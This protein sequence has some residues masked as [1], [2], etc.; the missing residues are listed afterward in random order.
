[1]LGPATR[2]PSRSFRNLP[3]VRLL[4]VGQLNTYDVLWADTVVFTDAT[5]G[6]V[7]R[8]DLVRL[9]DDRLR[10]ART[11]EVSDA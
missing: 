5:I 6:M 10:H 2:S 1:M 9:A 4:T 11:K 3:Q 8:Q 7:G